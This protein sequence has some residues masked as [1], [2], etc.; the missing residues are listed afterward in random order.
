MEEING[1]EVVHNKK[2]DR[3]EADLKEEVVQMIEINWKWK[4][5]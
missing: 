4:N 3:W 2:L 1:K 5:K